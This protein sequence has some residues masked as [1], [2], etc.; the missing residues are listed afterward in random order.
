MIKMENGAYK[1][2]LGNWE[3]RYTTKEGPVTLPFTVVE[4]EVPEIGDFLSGGRLVKRKGYQ[5]SAEGKLKW[6][7]DK[8]ATDNYS[9]WAGSP[10]L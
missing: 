4:G 8:G 7:S 9:N 2:S 3:Y 5:V 1:D 10:N 6:P